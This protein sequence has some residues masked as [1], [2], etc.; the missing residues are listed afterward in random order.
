MFNL[1]EVGKIAGIEP[2]DMTKFE[3]IAVADIGKVMG[4]TFS[5]ST[6]VDR[7]VTMGG[8]NGSAAVALIDYFAVASGGEAI[9]F[10]DLISA[11]HLLGAGGNSIRC[12]SA[13]YE[14][15]KLMDYITLATIGNSNDFGDLTANRSSL[16]CCGS[17]TRMLIMGG[18]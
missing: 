9:D 5:I 17:S 14:T 15:G 16:D 12:I 6:L 2:G 3:T 10:G 13:G 11:R 4:I 18:L 7:A 1:V 8:Y